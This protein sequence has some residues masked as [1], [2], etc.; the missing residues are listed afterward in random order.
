METKRLLAVI[1][2]VLAVLSF[3]V[4]AYP[5]LGMAVIFLALAQVI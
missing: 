2:L 4:T 3:V 5:L 1:G